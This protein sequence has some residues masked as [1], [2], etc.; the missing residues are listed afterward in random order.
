MFRKDADQDFLNTFIREV[1]STEALLFLT[2][3]DEKTNGVMM[4]YGNDVAV[5]QLGP[6]YDFFVNK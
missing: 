4:L 1:D 6:K 3:G 5:A 2:C